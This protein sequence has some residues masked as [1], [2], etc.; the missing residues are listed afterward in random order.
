[1]RAVIGKMTPEEIVQDRDLRSRV[2]WRIGRAPG[3]L[4]SAGLDR[5]PR[6]EVAP[7]ANRSL[8][9]IESNLQYSESFFWLLIGNP[10]SLDERTVMERLSKW[11]DF[12]PKQV[13]EMVHV[14]CHIGSEGALAEIA[15]DSDL[16][17]APGPAFSSR[18]EYA[19]QGETALFGLSLRTIRLERTETFEFALLQALRSVDTAKLQL[20]TLGFS[21]LCMR[22]F[23]DKDY[24]PARAEDWPEFAALVRRLA[25]RLAK[26][27]KSSEGVEALRGFAERLESRIAAGGPATGDAVPGPK[28]KPAGKKRSKKKTQPKRRTAP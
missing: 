7:I 6:E 27:R 11:P 22:L 16:F 26:K 8:G 24:V 20:Q 10:S 12:T 3:F 2:L 15:K 4:G 9:R 5:F 13:S 19:V 28:K 17:A 14:L 1:L 21:D 18:I 23:G 25:Q